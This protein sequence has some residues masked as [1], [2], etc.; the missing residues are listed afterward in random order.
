MV[1]T[2]FYKNSKIYK[3]IDN[4]NGN[5]YIGSTC[6]KLC[7]RL[8][9]HRADYKQYLAGKYHYVTSFKILENNNYD[10]ILIENCPCDNKEQLKAKERYYIESLDCVNKYITGRTMKEYQQ[11]NKEKLSEYQKMYKQENIEKLKKYREDNKENS[12]KYRKNNKDKL[13]KKFDCECGGHYSYGHKAEHFKTKKHQ[14]YIN[15]DDII[16]P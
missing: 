4:T 7:Q 13:R 10:I 16:E 12:Q 6:K 11:D 5:I 15:N 8:A 1:N 3:I 14:D 9:Q 2:D